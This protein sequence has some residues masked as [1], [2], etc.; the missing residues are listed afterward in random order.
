M[1]VQ[2]AEGC[3]YSTLIA[4]FIEQ[5]ASLDKFILN[6][7]MSNGTTPLPFTDDDSFIFYDDGVRIQS[8]NHISFIFYDML[9]GMEIIH[10]EVFP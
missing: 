9:V 5:L 6:I 7:H 8:D 2:V 10:K 4:S 3:E 1:S